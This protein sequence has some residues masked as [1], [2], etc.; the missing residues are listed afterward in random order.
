MFDPY[1]SAGEDWDMWLRIARY[2]EIRGLN[3]VVSCIRLHDRNLTSRAGMMDQA[4]Q[5]ILD[6]FFN[7]PDLPVHIRQLKN[8]ARSKAK[9]AAGV[10]AARRGD[11]K[12]SVILCLQALRFQKF[13]PDAYNLLFRSIF[14]LSI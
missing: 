2:F 12:L 14:R 1:L 7:Q 8:K 9:I 3:E 4:Y 5:T 11:Y 10:L 13:V 6:K